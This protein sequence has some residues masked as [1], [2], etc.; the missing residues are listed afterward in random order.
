MQVIPKVGLAFELGRTEAIK[1]LVI[2]SL[3]V[4]FFSCWEIQREIAMELI[5]QD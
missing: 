2:A 4:G 1:S 3:M 5:R